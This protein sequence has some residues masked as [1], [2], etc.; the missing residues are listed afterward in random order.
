MAEVC[1]RQ[2]GTGGGKERTCSFSFCSRCS[3]IEPSPSSSCCAACIG[4]ARDQQIR[5]IRARRHPPTCV[6]LRRVWSFGTALPQKIGGFYSSSL[7]MAPKFPNVSYLS[8]PAPWP[9]RA[10]SCA[11][12]PPGPR[13]RCEGAVL[14]ARLTPSRLY[15]TSLQGEQMTLQHN[16]TGPPYLRS[17][18]ATCL[19]CPGRKTPV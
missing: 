2:W 3:C 17:S 8:A 18:S 5:R 10:R 15:G 16:S 12:A 1:G 19:L 4:P 14:S 11:G 9:A 7:K 6:L 13:P